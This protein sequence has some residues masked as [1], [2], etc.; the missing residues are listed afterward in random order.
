MKMQD[1]IILREIV[2]NSRMGM[3]AIDALM[4]YV[5]KEQFAREISR[6][7]MDYGAYYEKAANKLSQVDKHIYKSSLG[8]SNML[9]SGIWMQTFMDSSTSHLAEMMIQGANR[10]ITEMYKALH[11][12][13]Y[14]STDVRALAKE[15][16]DME[17]KSINK[18][19]DYL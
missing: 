6:Q 1:Q 11:R 10:G 17:E 2:K 19:R 15:L 8:K 14:C 18:L 4:P 12:N 16:M 13:I 9:R 5:K 7:A 3:E